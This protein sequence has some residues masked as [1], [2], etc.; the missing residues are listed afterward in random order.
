MVSKTLLVLLAIWLMTIF[1]DQAL[2]SDSA[3]STMLTAAQTA[4][5]GCQSKCGNLTIPYPFGTSK[6]CAMTDEYIINCDTV[7]NVSTPLLLESLQVFDLSEMQL[8]VNSGGPIAESCRSGG[9]GN[10]ATNLDLSS[11][12]YALS[13]SGNK[14]MV[15]GCHHY[16]II[17]AYT[18]VGRQV[19]TC[20]AL[21]T[22]N[23]DLLDRA[24]Q[25]IGCCQ[26]PLPK[27]LQNFNATIGKIIYDT[28]ITSGKCSYAFIVKRSEFEFRGAADLEGPGI[29]DRLSNMPIVL[30]WFVKKDS[31]RSARQNS[32]SYACKKNTVCI[33][34]DKELNVRGYRC[35]CRQGYEGNPYLNCTDVNECASYPCY[36]DCENTRGGY[37]CHCP[38]GYHGDGR[39]DGIGCFP[40]NLRLIFILGL[41]VGLGSILFV[42]GGYCVYL[43]II[44]RK[45]IKRRAKNFKCNGGLLLQQQMT[46]EE[47]MTEKTRLF[48]ANELDKA[49]DRFNE[50]RVLGSGGQGTVYK[51]MLSDGNLVAVKKHKIGS[52]SQLGEFINEIAILSQI[53]HRNI[54]KLLGCCLETDVPLLVYEFISN[55]TL[56]KYIHDAQEEFPITWEMRLQIALDVAGALNYLHSSSSNPIFHK[57]V[58]TSNILLDAKYRAKLSDFGS[59]RSVALDQTHLTTKVQG[60]FG[61]LDPEFF[62]SSQYTEK[63]DVYSFGVVLVEL[64]TGKKAVVKT[65]SDNGRSLASWFLSSMETSN[66]FDILAARVL[67]EVRKETIFAVANLAKQSLNMDGKQRPTMRQVLLEL[68]AIS[69][70]QGAPISFL[71]RPST[72][73]EQ[74]LIEGAEAN[75]VFP[76]PAANLS[77]SRDDAMRLLNLDEE[78]FSTT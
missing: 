24:C 67:N 30:D 51:G 22:K 68:E 19:L 8:T 70:H 3:A 75:S 61:Y 46:C 21:C 60:T 14:F 76:F 10:D 33:D 28:N 59:S 74:T 4:K 34:V 27:G 26:V 7:K 20:V 40:R 38:S 52:H 2:N 66:L 45:E 50:D 72:T 18:S 15:V 53:N 1:S 11:S 29:E 69:H 62:Q 25:G 13:S 49:T 47:G 5:P 64:L 42:I 55:G 36:G 56:S 41:S 17:E 39:K 44:R 63:S 73:L 35:K 16:G 65:Q 32:S 9:T 77:S 54:V 6:G 37:K 78:E 57:D 12:P 23:E 31:C 71:N 58:K 43:A 48:T